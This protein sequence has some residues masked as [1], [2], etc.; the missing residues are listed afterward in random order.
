MKQQG[1]HMKT[2]REKFDG[3]VRAIGPLFDQGV[4]GIPMLGQ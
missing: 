1:D 4:C 2:I 3:Q